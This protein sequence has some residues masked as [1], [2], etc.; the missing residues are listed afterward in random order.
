MTRV[1]LVVL[2][3]VLTTTGCGVSAQEH[4]TPIA[5]ARPAEPSEPAVERGALEVPVYFVRSADLEPVTRSAREVSAQTAV[6]LLLAGPTR[7]EVTSGVRTALAPQPLAVMSSS[8][9]PAGTEPGTAVVA[10]TRDFATVSGSNQLL[11]LAQVVWTLTELP[12][13]ERVVITV[14]GVPVEVPTDD[15]LSRQ[16]VTRSHY[17]SVSPLQPTPSPTATP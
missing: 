17:T 1:V 12:G 9:A 14:D 15:G 10:A 8:D 5:V 2:A 3:L 13:I 11:A 16:P 6:D 4:P 7:R